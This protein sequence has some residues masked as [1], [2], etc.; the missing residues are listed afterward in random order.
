MLIKNVA[1]AARVTVSLSDL[2]RPPLPK[3]VRGK[4]RA[5]VLYGSEGR[6]SRTKSKHIVTVHIRIKRPHFLDAVGTGMIG[7]EPLPRFFPEIEP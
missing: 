7:Y 3:P 4:E 2:S 6:N 1:A 5:M